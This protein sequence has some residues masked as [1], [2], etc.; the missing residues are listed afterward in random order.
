MN[1]VNITKTQ[2]WH[3]PRAQMLVHIYST[4]EIYVPF[5]PAYLFLPPI[6]LASAQNLPFL[7]PKPLTMSFKMC[8]A[9]PSEKPLVTS[10]TFS[11][12]LT[13]AF[14]PSPI[15]VLS[16]SQAR[17]MMPNLSVYFQY[18]QPHQ[19]L[20]G[21]QETPNKW[22]SKGEYMYVF[23]FWVLPTYM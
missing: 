8:R 11:H 2:G 3:I 17:A 19:D 16:T 14:T 9:L 5:A 6:T 15:T 23:A 4:V 1:M 10:S 18:L 7:C 21:L 22:M 13:N 20:V 12:L